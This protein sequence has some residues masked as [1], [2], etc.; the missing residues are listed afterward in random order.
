MNSMPATD[1][2]SFHK[3][4]VPCLKCKEVF[5]NKDDFIK[6]KKRNKTCGTKN[7]KATTFECSTCDDGELFSRDEFVEHVPTH[8]PNEPKEKIVSEAHQFVKSS[9]QFEFV[10]IVL[11]FL[12]IIYFHECDVD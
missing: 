6:H 2:K 1:W 7:S 12:T 11:Y 3:T 10:A 8:L 9:E 4:H 5:S